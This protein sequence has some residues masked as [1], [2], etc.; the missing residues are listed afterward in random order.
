MLLLQSNFDHIVTSYLSLCKNTK[1]SI[2]GEV[3]RNINKYRKI[4]P[5]EV[6]TPK[7]K[8]V[9]D[10]LL[11]GMTLRQIAGELSMKYDSVNFHYK[12]IY[13]KLEVNSKIEL[14]LRYSNEK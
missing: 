6:L 14:I 4:D 1:D 8:V 10:L 2:V 11:E 7:E 3:D 13:R 12:N 5:Q 9:F